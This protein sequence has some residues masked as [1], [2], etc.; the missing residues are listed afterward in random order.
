ME[1]TNETVQYQ[2]SKAILDMLL[3]NRL[4]TVKEYAEIDKKNQATFAVCA[5]RITTNRVLGIRHSRTAVGTRK[6]IN[7]N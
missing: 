1:K 2:M 5:V 4:I 6:P 7:V 3:K